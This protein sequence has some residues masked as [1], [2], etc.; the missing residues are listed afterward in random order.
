[1]I[2]EH[3]LTKKG[4]CCKVYSNEE[5]II[6]DRIRQH[7]FKVNHLTVVSSIYIGN[8]VKYLESVFGFLTFYCLNGEL[9]D[10]LKQKYQEFSALRMLGNDDPHVT[11]LLFEL[12]FEMD[13]VIC[14]LIPDGY[15]YGTCEGT[16]ERFIIQSSYFEDFVY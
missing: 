16:G 10:G 6:I 9:P 1:M 12:I 4:I 13:D 2:K 7:L 14:E 3:T 5:S 11:D 15:N 8:P